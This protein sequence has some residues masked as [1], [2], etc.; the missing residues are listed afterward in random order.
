[1]ARRQHGVVTRRD[2]LRIGFSSAAIEHR[3]ATGRLRPV[4]RGVYTVGWPLTDRKQGWMAAV[5]ICGEGALLSHGSAAALWGVGPEGEG[6]VDV[7]IRRHCGISRPGM[8]AR[9]RPRLAE[10]DVTERHGIPVTTPV[11]T[12]IDQA[13]ELTSNQLER[14]VNEADK[15]DVIDPEALRMALDDYAGEPGVK[16]LRTL[17]DRLTFRLSDTELE[18]LFR[19]IATAAGLPTPLTKEMVNG[20]EV[21]FHWPDLGLV[22]ETDGWR[23]HRTPSAQTR[24]ALRDQIHTASGLTALR[25]SHYQVAHEPQ[26][27]LQILSRTLANLPPG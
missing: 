22:V 11:R 9:S 25:F 18:V 19:P 12:L 3:L 21:D 5:L 6:P 17:I 24:D 23:Y 8:N 1:M 13:T 4:A 14:M 2:L 10:R 16:P 7:S 27:V 26:H 20:F 15:H